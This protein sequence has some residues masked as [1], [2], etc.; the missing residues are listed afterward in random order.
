M[1]SPYQNTGVEQQRDAI[2][3]ALM[4]INSPPP[5]TPLP[6]MPQFNP[7]PQM[8]QMPAPGGPPQGA[9]IGSGAMPQQAPLAAP[10]PPMGGMM[11]QPGGGM[12]QPGANA[13]PQ[14][15]MPSMKPPGM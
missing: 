15:P 12:M 8:P 2:T 7:A 13:M 14:A 9:P 4:Q 11:Q 3:Q 10:A 6:Q 5:Q 1:P